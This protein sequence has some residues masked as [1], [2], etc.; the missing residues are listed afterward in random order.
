MLHCIPEGFNDAY[1]K[2]CVT[3]VCGVE[4]GE[5][6]HEEGGGVLPGVDQVRERSLGVPVAPQTLDEAQ[7]GRQTLDDGA[8][9]VRV[10]VAHKV[11]RICEGHT[12]HDENSWS[13]KISDHNQCLINNNSS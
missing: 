11:L 13:T 4:G 6:D 5:G 8:Q 7:P 2:V 3:S 12:T 9:A 1:N 10:A